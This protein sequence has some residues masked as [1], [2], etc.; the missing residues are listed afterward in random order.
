MGIPSA[1]SFNVMSEMTLFGL[2]TT[3]KSLYAERAK[4]LAN[5]EKKLKAIEAHCE[6]NKQDKRA[7]RE[8]DR[9]FSQLR[10]LKKYF[11]IK[12]R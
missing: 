4:V 6:K 2:E 5:V 7:K 12:V 9:I 11:G 1:L 3:E 8:K 10:K